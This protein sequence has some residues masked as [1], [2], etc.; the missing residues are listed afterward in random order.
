M[1]FEVLHQGIAEQDIDLIGSICEPN[2]RFAF[3]EFF[4]EL[5]ERNYKIEAVE[6]PETEIKLEIIDFHQVYG[7]PSISREECRLNGVWDFSYGMPE[8][9]QFLMPSRSG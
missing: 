5:E 7:A 2:L 4:D 9:T 3:S 6:E 1:M 8:N